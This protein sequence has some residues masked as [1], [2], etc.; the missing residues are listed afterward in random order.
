ML[1]IGYESNIFLFYVHIA[2][3]K[4]S[5]GWGTWGNSPKLGKLSTESG[6]CITV[7][8]SQKHTVLPRV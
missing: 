4:Y 2:P 7:S 8:N 1:K 5:E 6:V 3:S